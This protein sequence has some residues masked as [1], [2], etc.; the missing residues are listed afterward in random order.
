MEGAG[1]E[2]REPSVEEAGQGERGSSIEGTG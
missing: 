1:Q 2:D